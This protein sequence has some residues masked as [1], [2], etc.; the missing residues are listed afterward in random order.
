MSL[1]ETVVAIGVLSVGLMSMAAL[2]TRMISTTS[3]SGYMS[4]AMQLA[5]EKLEDLNRFPCSAADITH[6]DANVIVSSGSSAGSLTAD[7]SSTITADGETVLV[8]YWDEVRF[9]ATGGAVREIKTGVNGG[10]FTTYTTVAHAPDGTV[11]T[12]TSTT[13]TCPL[14]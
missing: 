10:G 3:R 2:M 4:T 14:A 5:S 7:S 6:C 9:D 11:N 8:D 13:A 1:I 12:S